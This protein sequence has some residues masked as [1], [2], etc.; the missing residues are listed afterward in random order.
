MAPFIFNPHQ[1]SIGDFFV[2]YRE[3]LRWFSRGNSRTHANS[4]HGYCR[5]SRTRITG[6][7]KKKL[8]HPS[9]KNAVDTPKAGWRTVLLSE[10]VM[11]L[12]TA[13]CFV[14]C[15]M[16]AKSFSSPSVN[17]LLRIAIISLGPI[18]FNA[19]VLIV[20][21]IISMTAGP[22]LAKC[23]PRFASVMAAIAHLLAV[24][25][26]IGFFEFLWC[27]CAFCKR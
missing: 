1:F 17:G 13:I 14:I 23:A 5:L 26:L 10:I 16:F 21:F 15:Y 18:V 9:E 4:W 12:G 24:I 8:G 22:A 3:T 2:D 6:F 7:K 11:P 27:M 25:G 20:L 19:V